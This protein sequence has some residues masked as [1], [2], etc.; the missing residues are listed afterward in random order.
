MIKKLYQN[1]KIVDWT[2]DFARGERYFIRGEQVELPIHVGDK[3]PEFFRPINVVKNEE[4]VT[5]QEVIEIAEDEEVVTNQEV[6][7]KNE[8]EEVVENSLLKQFESALENGEVKIGRKFYIWD[9]KRIDKAKFES[10]EDKESL[11]Q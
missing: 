5:N 7:E 3:Y 6:I 2:F 9:G 1:L 11:L 8:D 4:V 10:A